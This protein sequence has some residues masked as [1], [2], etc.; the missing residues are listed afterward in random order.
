MPISRLLR[1]LLV[2][3]VL[4]AAAQPAA[5]AD[6]DSPL[7]DSLPSF[8]F[9]TSPPQ[10]ESFTITPSTVDV[11][12]S[13]QTV[14]VELH[15]TDATGLVGSPTITLDSQDTTQQ[16]GFGNVPRTS[17]SAT[18]GIYSK[19]VTLPQGAAPGTWDAQVFPLKDFFGNSNGQFLT[20]TS[21]TV[22]HTGVADVEAPQV[23]SFSMTPDTVDVSSSSQNVTISFHMTDVTGAVEPSFVFDH[24]DTTQTLA[25][26]P[27]TRKSGT[28]TDGIYERTITIPQGTA[29]GE[30]DALLFPPSDTLGNT[31]LSFLTPDTLTVT[32]ATPTDTSPPEL[33][34]FS[35][36]PENVD[37][38]S[39]PQTVTVSMHITDATGA[40]TPTLVLDHRESTALLGQDQVPRIS[41]TAQDGVYERTITIPQG[42]T[43][44]H[45]DTLLFPLSDTLLNT[46]SSFTTPG[47]VGVSLPPVPAGGNASISGEP[48][49]GEQLTCDTS[50]WSNSPT[51]FTYR[52]L[53]DGLQPAVGSSQFYFVKA[54]DVGHDLVCKVVA[55]NLGG[56]SVAATSDPVTIVPPPSGGTVSISGTPRLGQTLTCDTSGWSPTPTTLSYSW[57]R[58]GTGGSLAATETYEVAAEDVGHQLVCRVVAS[59][60]GGDSNAK[61]SD[62]V[63]VVA[64]PAGGTASISGTPKLGQTLTCNKS[65]WSGSPTSFAFAWLRDASA[66]PLAATKTYVVAAADVGHQL[67]C[68]VIATNAGGDSAPAISPAVTVVA[69]P[70]GGTA[71]ITGTPKQG[72]T[73][74]CNTTGWSGS[75]TTFAF[76]WLRDASSTPLASTKTYTV[77]A[78]DVGHQ[79]KCRVVATN[80]GGDSSPATSPAVDVVAPPAGGTASIA[81]TPKLG[82]SLTCNTTGWSGAPTS[83]SFAWLRDGIG[84]ALATTK[85]YVVAAGDVGHE[86]VCRVIAKN[87]GGDSNAA[88]SP[89]VKVVAPPAGG[90]ASITGTPKQGQVLTCNTTG[91]SGAPTSFAFAWLR[92]ASTTPLATTKTYTV[93][94]ADVGHE[95]KCRVVASNAGGDSS[96]ATSPAVT[97]VAPPAG[98][99]ASITGTPKQGQVLTCNTTGWS[100]SPAS[101]S[102]AWLRDASATAVASTK[103]YTV[104]AADVG[105]ELVCRVIA[106]NAG[107]DSAPATSSA[108]K[109]VAPPAGGTASITGT[110]KQGQV[111]T[112]NTTGWSG[113]PTS[114]AFAWLRDGTGSAL[115][116]TKT[117]TVAAADVGHQLVCRVVAS[118]PGGDSAPT[119]SPAVKVIAPPAD[120]TATISGTPRVGQTLTCVT[121]DWSGEPTDFAYA[122]HRDASGTPFA[123]TKTYAVVAADVGHKL[124]CRV[125]ATNTGGDSAP[126]VSA[127]VTAEAVPTDGGDKGNTGD[128]GTTPGGDGGTTPTGDGGTTPGDGSTTPSGGPSGPT[129]GTADNGGG[130]TP[131]PDAQAIV[132]RILLSA[133]ATRRGRLVLS[134]TTPGGKLAVLATAKKKLRAFVKTTTLASRAFRITLKPSRKA[135]RLLRRKKRLKVK[136]TLSFAP[137][138]AAAATGSR[139]LTLK[140]RR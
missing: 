27:V 80:A 17:G 37:A 93:A 62:P 47:S 87:A 108:V 76:A 125:V 23:D 3:V 40:Q 30:W 71:S 31:A 140:L 118:N 115:A 69:P 49:S 101:F 63:D 126:A 82:Q 73:L 111:L 109:I 95:L 24:K 34:S 133:K 92:D 7:R 102:F 121:A 67:K 54:A 15:I 119:T 1:P 100:G 89:A 134:G 129:D 90:A 32:N 83:F 36:T 59:G 42:T 4:L 57:L 75:P 5:A 19:D 139:T 58:D 51:N 88:T 86:L 38:T 117:Y 22:V 131:K 60:A 84:S 78:G 29:S 91:W 77:A 9:D 39:G 26:G 138:G 48:R 99:T 103:T 14:T 50:G 98:G 74:T 56:N 13:S 112:C 52:W 18:D 64:P 120:G 55:S 106:K 11:T 16:A 12:G 44:G 113:S 127:P 97:V 79:L 94:A 114:F 72:Q 25:N 41:G 66:T 85:T 110:P 128:G 104:A 46:A 43:P 20:P 123:T 10:L 2:V 105:H 132:G 65:G 21:L 45:W 6:L 96:P 135:A 116:T 53:R 61:A 122:W 8:A 107:G 130:G 124:S 68:R 33:V 137:T 81:G 28:A 70:A 35:V 136:L